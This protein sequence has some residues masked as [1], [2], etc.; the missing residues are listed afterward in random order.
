[1]SAV[2]ST[3]E[4]ATPASSNTDLYESFAQRRSSELFI[5]FSGP[6]GCGIKAAINQ[7]DELLRQFGYTDVK[8]IKLSDYLAK[9][10]KDDILTPNL[11]D[12][13]TDCSR[14]FRR[15]RELQEAGRILREQTKNPAILAERA[16][17]EIALHR[18]TATGSQ[19]TKSH[20][21]KIA[22][23]IDQIKRPEEV[24]LLRA[25]YRN[26]FYLVG[27][28]RTYTQREKQLIELGIKKEEVGDLMEIDRSE[29]DQDGQRLDKTL[30]LANFFAPSETPNGGSNNEIKRL[31][32]LIHGDRMITPTAAERGMYA[33]FSA[34]LSSACMSRQVGAA[35]VNEAGEILSTGYNDVP[36]FGGGLY[37]QDDVGND[38][39]CINQPEKH[40][41]N[42]FHKR[43]VQRE[44]GVHID[45]FLTR[46]LPEGQIPE[47][48]DVEKS[49]LLE[50]L[51]KQTR[52]GSLI[53]FSRAVHAEMDAIVSLARNGTSGIRDAILYTTTFPC[54]NCARHIVASGITTVHYIEPYEKSMARE[55]HQDSISFEYAENSI[56]NSSRVRF[57]HFHGVS[58]QQYARF[59]KV[60]TRKDK[61]G[62]FIS[63]QPSEADKPIAEYLDNYQDF[64]IKAISHFDEEIRRIGAKNY[65]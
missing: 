40:C 59:F 37:S 56:T 55:L 25:V 52:L 12:L 19:D 53:E 30:Y 39:R 10:L 26:L 58:P 14:E 50:A 8:R 15:Y 31:I 21:P 13:P 29:N 18:R 51:Y 24:R 11:P 63:I 61:N 28:T 35:I 36:K 32:H 42:D 27:I 34:G 48:I 20:P 54:H 57:Q 62:K 4:Q 45:K 65:T 22:Y 1:M 60:L 16:I 17:Q 64:E 41:F 3:V 7:T 33:A 43:E 49:E 6:I 23:L 5:G 46:L 9:L 47:N 2:A 38:H 44:I